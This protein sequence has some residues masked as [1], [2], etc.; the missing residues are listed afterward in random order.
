MTHASVTV[1]LSSHLRARAEKNSQIHAPENY[2]GLNLSART[3][4]ASIPPVA[5]SP[6]V[7]ELPSRYKF[8]GRNPVE[9]R[10]YNLEKENTQRPA[11]S[12]GEVRIFH[13]G[14]RPN[15]KERPGSGG[16]FS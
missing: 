7:A 8:H 13:S 9:L 2:A 5:S 11:H 1:N 4:A 15:L 12:S 14:N 3:V 6:R 10:T 16:R